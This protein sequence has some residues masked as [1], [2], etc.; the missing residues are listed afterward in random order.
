MSHRA[1][2][3]ASEECARECVFDRR[4]WSGAERDGVGVSTPA[5]DGKLSCSGF[6]YRWDRCADL[7]RRAAM[8]AGAGAWPYGLSGPVRAASVQ[9][10]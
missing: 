8:R 4:L 3:S 10:L 6:D 1:A 7:S 9:P 2:H 5:E